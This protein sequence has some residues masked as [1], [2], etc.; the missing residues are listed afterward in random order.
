MSG[1]T[2]GGQRRATHRDAGGARRRRPRGERRRRR[3]RRMPC[4]RQGRGPRGPASGDR[5]RRAGLGG[6]GRPRDRGV[7]GAD[8]AGVP[9]RP[10]AARARPLGTSGGTVPSGPHRRLRR[11][12][13]LRARRAPRRRVPGGRRRFR[14]VR[15]TRGRGKG[16]RCGVHQRPREGHVRRGRHDQTGGDRPRHCTGDPARRVPRGTGGGAVR[17]RGRPEPAGARRRCARPPAHADPR[18]RRPDR[19]GRRD[20]RDLRRRRGR[21]RRGRRRPG[22]RGSPGGVGSGSPPGPVDPGRHRRRTQD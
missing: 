6:D 19:G 3:R 12:P 21:A 5:L 7:D 2:A 1:D 18:R 10:R 15:P 22:G 13:V 8:L 20:R 4:P 17:C 16:D 9:V 11:G 14:D